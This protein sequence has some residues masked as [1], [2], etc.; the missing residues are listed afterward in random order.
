M[1]VLSEALDRNLQKVM[2]PTSAGDGFSPAMIGPQA[3]TSKQVEFYKTL[4]N[5]KQMDD[6]ARENYKKGMCHIS[7]Q[8]MVNVIGHLVTLPW[9]PRPKAAPVVSATPSPVA[10]IGEGRYAVM[11]GTEL[12]FYEVRKPTEGKWAGFVFLSQLSGENHIPMR[13]K[14]EREAIY[15][16]IVKDVVGALKLYGQKIGRCG[17][18]RKTLTD[19][20]SREFGIGPVCRKALGL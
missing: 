4:V 19:Q 16:L 10:K 6:I 11:V 13:D 15:S 17:H 5:G 1:S 20:V 7:R 2:N 8:G 3:P 18:C 14:V 12:K 9:I